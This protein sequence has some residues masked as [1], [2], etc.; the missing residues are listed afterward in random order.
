MHVY[1]AL[2]NWFLDRLWVP[3]IS[4]PSYRYCVII[5][6]S[7]WVCSSYQRSRSCLEG[8]NG[9]RTR[10]LVSPRHL[11]CNAQLAVDQSQVWSK[12]SFM[13][14]NYY[15][16]RDTLDQLDYTCAFNTSV[17]AAEGFA[18]GADYW[19]N[20]GNFHTTMCTYTAPSVDLPNACITVWG[21]NYR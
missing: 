10:S 19:G 2:L 4:K 7:L 15:T 1:M 13:I 16:D 9:Y 20:I 5:V 8:S 12:D 3:S 18:N 21:C 6:L 11:A 14:V 17:V